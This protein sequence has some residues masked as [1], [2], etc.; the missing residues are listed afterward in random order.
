MG[1]TLGNIDL[2]GLGEIRNAN[3]QNLGVAPT[4]NLRAGRFYFSTADATLYVYDGTKWVDALSQG[5]YTFQNGIEIESGTRNVQIKL[6]TST[7]AGNITFTADSNGLAANAPTA[8]TSQAGLIEI[9]TDTEA[10][11]GTA[12][13]LAV[14]PKQLATKVDKLSSAPTAGTYTK[15]TI[16]SDGLVSSGG[17]LLATDIPDISATYYLASNPAGYTDNVGTVTSVNSTTP[18]ASGNVEITIPTV[19]NA[20]LTITQNGTSAGTFTA[21][22]STDTTIALTDTTYSDFTGATSSV[23]GAHGLVPAPTTTD[24]AKFL[25][26][27]GTWADTPTEVFCAEY[28]E[29]TYGQVLA[30][31]EAGK[32]VYTVVTDS[33]TDTIF[34]LTGIYVTAYEAQAVFSSNSSSHLMIA[35]VD[36]HDD[37]ST[38]STEVQEKL[39]SG[40]NIKTINNTS[41]LGSGNIDI[42]VPTKISDLTDDTATYPVDKADTLTGLTATVAELN[43]LDGV[44]A[45]ATEINVLDGITASTTELNY[46]DGVTS[47][48][49]DQL[50]AKVVANSAITGATKCKITYDSKGLVTS[51]ADLEASDIPSLSLSKITDVTASAAEVNVLDGITAST[52]ELNILDGVTVTASDINSVTSKIELTDLSID[53]NSTNYLTYDNTTGAIGANVDTTVTD[54]S[55]NLVTSGAVYSAI[56]TALVGGVIYQGTWDITSAT[57]YSG[58]TLPVKKGYL[59]YVTGTG[60]V[61][62]GGIEWN[63]GDYLLVNENV[64]SGGTL[65]GKVSKIDNTEAADIVRT[66]ATQ[67]LTNKT[68]DADDNTI[69]DLT[70]SNLKSGVL[71]TTVRAESSASDTALASEKA[72]ATAIKNF[73]T[74]SSTNTLTNKTFDANGTGNSISNIEVADFASGVVQ[75][76]VRGTSTASDTALAS[77]KAIATALT[78][79]TDKL[80]AN[81]PALT[82]SGGQCTW[83]ISNTLGT[84]D[85]VC[86]LYEISTN[87]VVWPDW[88]VTSSTVTVKV[89]A[90]ADIA[91]NTYRAVIIG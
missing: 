46:V 48:I 41:I 1:K 89:N 42:T 54:S 13:G 29:T 5:D 75:T 85:V 33:G 17:S 91:A 52:A 21:N 36:D 7:N 19:N 55:T 67:T 22:S 62:I 44:T 40:T 31:Y 65:S 32:L 82:V 38:S 2:G 87:E 14:N 78:A 18:D 15:V 26:G 71:Q 68:I 47:S 50:N 69:T 57:D 84:A 16:N 72:I 49:Q 30:A 51:G 56:G 83:E 45:T 73:I 34:V 6:A 25:K 9:A 59:Y 64:A 88:T 79:K 12:T 60:P 11:T 4:T 43:I 24:V 77:E 53:N 3:F 10:S 20:T 90:A 74:A 39:V 28:G 76:T 81:N 70:T 37:W 58:I 63:A 61:T 8:S 80:T 86:M 23:A 27:D 35:M 66:A